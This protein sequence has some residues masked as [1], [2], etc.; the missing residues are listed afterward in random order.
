M[1]WE[2]NYSEHPLWQAVR[3][4]L[5]TLDQGADAWPGADRDELARV[6]WVLSYLLDLG[7]S[8]EPLVS[9]SALEACRQA[10]VNLGGVISNW[11]SSGEASYLSDAA[12]PRV[13]AVLDALRGWLVSP[14]KHT[15]SVIS[16]GRVFMQ[17]AGREAQRLHDQLG[18]LSAQVDAQRQQ[19]DADRAASEQGT[20]SRDAKAA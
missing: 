5:E 1:S 14:D 4:A 3:D 9:Q 20:P 15:R 11:R 16:A 6:R 7:S 17:E 8:A 12:G 2:R 18:E 10:V 19:L 13:E